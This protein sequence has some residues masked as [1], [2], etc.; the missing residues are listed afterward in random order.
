MDLLCKLIGGGCR[1]EDDV[2]ENGFLHE[3]NCILCTSGIHTQEPAHT[4]Y[5][6]KA[7]M[8][9]CISLQNSLGI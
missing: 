2:N 9:I 1:Y 8:L 7:L 5:Y 4:A 6:D 3:C